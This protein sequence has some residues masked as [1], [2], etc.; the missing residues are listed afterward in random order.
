MIL[1]PIWA[2]RF[3][4]P[5][6]R[7][8]LQKWA[9]EGLIYPKPIKAG[10][11]YYVESDACLVSEI[12][13]GR[14]R[15]KHVDLPPNLYCS[16]GYFY[17]RDPKTRKA[18]GIG[19]D[20]HQA[21][22]QSIAAN[23][24][25]RSD[26]VTLVDRLTGAAERTVNHWCDKFDAIKPGYRLK[27]L[28]DGLGDRILSKLEPLQINQWLDKWSGKARMRQQQLG[29]AKAVFAEAIGKGWIKTNPAADLT[30]P[31]PE[32][33]RQ[34]LT[35]EAYKAIHAQASPTLRHAME[36][37]LMAPMRRAGVLSLQWAQ[38]KD[39]YLWAEHAKGGLRVRIPLSLHLP[40]VGWTLGDVIG[41]C[42]DNVVSR[43]VIHHAKS[44]GK[45]KAGD[46][47]RDKTIEQLFRDA[48][49]AAG[50]GGD[51]PPTFHEIRSLAARLWDAQGVNVKV[52]LG[53]KTDKM[54]ALYKDSRGAEWV[55]LVNE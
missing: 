15:S 48:R 47:I 4:P 39:G 1:L 54:S 42:R 53:H 43:Y 52:L 18:I 9:R 23:L 2:E 34:R 21:I 49:V 6:H 46:K 11:A 8:T 3:T 44:V 27:Y 13:M 45:A 5:P 33:K 19:R 35:I 22:T 20:K 14:R 26:A 37:A 16:D 25:L 36:I 38:I 30:T 7:N 10:K 32:T 51:N 31:S 40:S 12:S 41:R 50:I 28:R 55:T 29:I 17:W 24:H